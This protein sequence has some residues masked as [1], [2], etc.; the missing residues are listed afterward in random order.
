MEGERKACLECV[1]SLRLCSDKLPSDRACGLSS[2]A[3]M[4]DGSRDGWHAVLDHCIPRF[5]WLG[6]LIQVHAL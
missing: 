2:T 6:S 5:T 1:T 3:E 4:G